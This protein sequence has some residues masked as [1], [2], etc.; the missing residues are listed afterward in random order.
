MSSVKAL[1][2]RSCGLEVVEEVSQDRGHFII[3]I[4]CSVVSEVAD[5]CAFSEG[6]HCDACRH[7][8]LNRIAGERLSVYLV[9]SRGHSG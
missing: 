6:T 4:I 5:Y 9:F 3:P 2:I 7:Q 8:S 1:D